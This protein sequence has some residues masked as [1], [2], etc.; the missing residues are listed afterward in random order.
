MMRPETSSPALERLR[1]WMAAKCDSGEVAL[2]VDPDD[3]VPVGLV[4]VEAH[5][6]P[7]DAGVVDQD[8][9]LAPGVDGL[10]TRVSAPVHELTS[11]AV[12][13]RLRPRPP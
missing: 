13:R 1:Q 2:Q 11:S 6:V 7:E 4:H 9:E 12:E 3:V 5:L 10:A 8:V